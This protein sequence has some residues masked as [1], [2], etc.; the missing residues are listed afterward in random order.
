MNEVSDERLYV[1]RVLCEKWRL[2]AMLGRGG[3][4][5]VW[6]ATHRNGRRVA[7]K[8]LNAALSNDLRLRERFTREGYVANRIQH[9][10]VTEVIDD[11]VSEDGL[12]LLVL[13]LLEG[14]TLRDRWVDAG[15]KLATA[16]VIDVAIDVLDILVAA[17]AAGVVH[18]DVKPDNI[19]VL[20]DGTIKL[21]DFGIARL[22]E[23]S[24]FD[25]HTSTGVML[26]TPAYMPPEQALGHWDRVSAQTDVFAVGATMW[27]LLTGTLVHEA[28][29]AQEL[30][31][32]AG[33]KQARPLAKVMPSVPKGLARVIDRALAFEADERWTDADAMKSALIAVRD[34]VDEPHQPDDAAHAV[35]LGD[36]RDL[37]DTG[38]TRIMAD[39]GDM[40]EGDAGDT[41][42]LADEDPSPDAAPHEESPPS[43]AMSIAD[44]PRALSEVPVVPASSPRR[45]PLLALGSLS[46]LAAGFGAAQL[47]GSPSQDSTAGRDSIPTSTS[48]APADEEPKQ[49]PSSAPSTPAPTTSSSAPSAPSASGSTSAPPIHR[50]PAPRPPAPAVERQAPPFDATQ[51]QGSLNRSAAIAQTNCGHLGKANEAVTIMVTWN[52]DGSVAT[53][54]SSGGNPVLRSCAEPYFGGAVTTPFSGPSGSASASIMGRGDQSGRLP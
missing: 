32:A 16:E 46:L 51:A 26:G 49:V 53:R 21:L 23:V 7:I 20:E 47:F 12:V 36:A 28:R 5:T 45:G 33:T 18:R 15:R 35:E 43:S 31:I 54:R 40:T 30:V 24:G 1:G 37:T 10:G 48:S 9:A 13:E 14:Q 34:G 29:T 19:F 11:E 44:E 50:V 25:H 22:R 2:E 41:Q 52:A 17:H 39:A 4:A 27:T 38:D 42:N 8:V 6:A 3:M